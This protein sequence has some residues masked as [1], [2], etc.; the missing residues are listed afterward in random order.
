MSKQIFGR[1]FK[2]HSM[3]LP[4][5]IISETD[6]LENPNDDNRKYQYNQLTELQKQTKTSP[7]GDTM[8]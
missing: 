7:Y 1:A 8:I 3:A 4:K 6:P 5:N 2:T